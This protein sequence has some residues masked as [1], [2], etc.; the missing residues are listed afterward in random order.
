LSLWRTI[1]RGLSFEAE[2]YPHRSQVHINYSFH[3]RFES[4]NCCCQLY[5]WSLGNLV[6]THCTGSASKFQCCRRSEGERSREVPCH[7]QIFCNAASASLGE[8]TFIATLLMDSHSPMDSNWLSIA[9]DRK[10]NYL[11]CSLQ[12]VP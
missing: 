2:F 10:Y 1:Q 12:N 3:Q 6:A 4:E 7:N 9:T 11:K 5:C 8:E